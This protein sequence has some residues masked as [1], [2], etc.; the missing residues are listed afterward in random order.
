MKR[1]VNLREMSATT[2]AIVNA[3]SHTQ[4]IMMGLQQEKKRLRL[5]QQGSSASTLSLQ[6]KPPASS[7]FNTK[8]VTPDSSQQMLVNQLQALQV[9]LLYKMKY[10]IRV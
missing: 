6:I 7:L 2:P 3:E 9:K 10:L 1:T 8:M 5:L 4:K